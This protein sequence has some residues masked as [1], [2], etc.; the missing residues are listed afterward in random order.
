[1]LDSIRA[2]LRR[3]TDRRRQA[4]RAEH[5]VESPDQG[6]QG[7]VEPSHE[8]H[9]TRPEN[10]N[11]KA[12]VPELILTRPQTVDLGSL[13]HLKGL[14]EP[15]FAPPH[16]VEADAM[17]PSSS[18]GGIRARV[19]RRRSGGDAEVLVLEGRKGGAAGRLVS[20]WEAAAEVRG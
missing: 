9:H 2:R 18:Q 5:S 15:Q 13:L 10:V 19:E 16:M 14:D 4:S 7:L 11:S 17:R 20:D 8:L 12:P 6:F 3:A 1:M